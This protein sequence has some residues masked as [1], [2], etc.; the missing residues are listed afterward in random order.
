MSQLSASLSGDVS[1]NR[2]NTLIQTSP[3]TCDS[4]MSCTQYSCAWA[5]VQII[6]HGP[7]H[8]LQWSQSVIILTSNVG[9]FKAA[10]IGKQRSEVCH[11]LH[12][13]SMRC[14]HELSVK[15]V[16]W[17][18]LNKGTPAAQ[19]GQSVCRTPEHGQSTRSR[20]WWRTTGN[21]S[22][23]GRMKTHRWMA[24]SARPA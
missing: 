1:R 7:A 23:G 22:A 15:P 13:P 6:E 14:L 18:L 11:Q 8:G 4:Y 16:A 17:P 5:R 9:A 2:I 10:Q 19:P 12:L 24:W 21:C 20:S 3:F